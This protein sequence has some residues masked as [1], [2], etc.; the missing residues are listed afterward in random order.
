MELEFWSNLTFSRCLRLFA[1]F[2]YILC[3]WLLLA[4]KHL[5]MK[6]R[7]FKHS[8]QMTH[9][10]DRKSCSSC[11]THVIRQQCGNL[12]Q[13]LLTPRQVSNI[14]F[15]CSYSNR[16]D[17][18]SLQAKCHQS[19]WFNFFLRVNTDTRDSA[20]RIFPRFLPFEEQTPQSDEEIPLPTL[21]LVRASWW[22]Q[23]NQR[24]C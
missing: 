7:V 14:T 3:D 24:V 6:E 12:C 23:W 16:K 4:I 11:L 9:K 5:M 22:Q 8:V 19:F 1:I 21:E 18:A 15:L 10:K 20:Y 2:L 17:R 13:P